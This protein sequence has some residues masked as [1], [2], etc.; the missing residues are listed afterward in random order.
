MVIY[1][2]D[3]FYGMYFFYLIFIYIFID[4]GRLK[5][6]ME[7]GF[8]FNFVVVEFVVWFYVRCFKFIIEFFCFF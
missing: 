8:V 3:L 2:K 6:R 4:I 5:V 1:F 7:L